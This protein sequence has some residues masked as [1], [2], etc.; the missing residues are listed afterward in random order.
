MFLT[1]TLVLPLATFYGCAR[2]ESNALIIRNAN[3]LIEFSNNV[4][5]G[6]NYKGMTVLL[7]SDIDF[8]GE[9]SNKFKPIGKDNETTFEGVFDGQGHTISNLSIVSTSE[10]VGLFG[11]TKG[12]GIKN[13]VMDSSCSVLGS[14]IGDLPVTYIGGIVGHVEPGDTVPVIDGCVNMANV[15]FD[16]NL[17]SQVYSGASIGGVA[18][19]FYPVS[20]NCEIRNCANYGLVTYS[21]RCQFTAIGGVLGSFINQG[22]SFKAALI[23]KNCANYGFIRDNGES[24]H[25]LF[26]GGIIGAALQ[27][28]IENCINFGSS[29]SFI[30]D[31]MIGKIIGGVST[32]NSKKTTISRCFWTNEEDSNTTYGYA[33]STSIKVINS[34]LVKSDIH[35]MNDLNNWTEYNDGHSRWMM[36][37]LNGGSLDRVT[38]D[39]VIVLRKAFISPE[40]YGHSFDYWCLDDSCSSGAYSGGYEN[41]T[42]LYAHWTKRTYSLT[43][44]FGNGTLI[45]TSVAFNETIVYPNTTGLKGFHGWNVSTER[46]PGHDLVI[47][48]IVL[49]EGK[50][51]TAIV[52]GVVTGGIVLVVIVGFVV[53][54][55]YK[56]RLIEE[57]VELKRDYRY[58]DTEETCDRFV[59]SETPYNMCTPLVSQE[60]VLERYQDLYP[61]QYCAPTMIEALIEAGIDRTSARSAVDSCNNNAIYAEQN[62]MLFDGFTKDDAAAVTLYTYDFGRNKSRSNPYRLINRALAGKNRNDLNRV[63]GLLFTVLSPLRKLNTIEG[64][65][66]YK[67]IKE[68]VNTDVYKEGSIIVWHGFSSTTTD[69]KAVKE[70]LTTP[71]NS[72]GGS[73]NV[74]M[75]SIE[76]QVS[77]GTLFIIKDGWGYDVQPFSLLSDAREILIEPERQFKVASV[78]QSEIVVIELIMLDTP[79]ILADIY[80]NNDN[81]K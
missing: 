71:I 13:V 81:A 44:D 7:D 42:D 24:T 4:R 40:M 46:M 76:D 5:G 72:K 38:K 59:E 66:L 41:V 64:E 16:G 78:I 6:T 49:S 15:S 23:A 53:L 30:V 29:K 68:T 48:P 2:S 55:V 50:S 35:V 12:P 34:H 62:G 73:G 43:F 26:I 54:M 31:S 79:L 45:V 28:S 21:G 67:G 52:V 56:K 10:Y 60:D 70:F 8:N 36:L 80:D 32:G 39:E 63:R 11:S 58:I 61:I 75:K 14:Y 37:H 22:L 47:G 65:T 27:I 69:M 25:M 3:E 19:Y 20:L 18:G 33:L 17:T 1:L 51:G 57:M 9:E 74:E 77:S